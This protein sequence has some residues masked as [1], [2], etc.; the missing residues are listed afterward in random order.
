MFC[1]CVC[2]ERYAE[3][4][5]QVEALHQKC[6][7]F[8]LFSFSPSLQRLPHSWFFS[9]SSPP[10]SITILFPE[11][12]CTPPPTRQPVSMWVCVRLC[13]HSQL[14][15]AGKHVLWGN[16]GWYAVCSFWKTHPFINSSSL[17]PS[18]IFIKCFSIFLFC[19]SSLCVNNPTYGLPFIPGYFHPL[20]RLPFI[21]TNR[22]GFLPS[23]HAPHRASSCRQSL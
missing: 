4:D 20:R 10:L 19:Q 22:V 5:G 8:P 11:S 18:L 13:V 3:S 1:A 23:L 15:A 6:G 16:E 17:P 7:F 2:K 21:V 12:N 14:G 9:S